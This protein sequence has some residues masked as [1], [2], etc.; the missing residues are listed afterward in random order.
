MKPMAL[1]LFLLSFPHS[2]LAAGDT[3][4][5]PC[6]EVD[7]NTSPDSPFRKI[8]VEDQDGTGLCYAYSA[9]AIANYWNVK[10][11]GEVSQGFHPLYLAGVYSRDEV[12]KDVSG[13]SVF[14]TLN[15]LKRSGNCPNDRVEKLIGTWSRTGLTYAETLSLIEDS[16]ESTIPKAQSKVSMW[17]KRFL[18]QK[19]LGGDEAS[20][21]RLTQNSAHFLRSLPTLSSNQL[22]QSM[23]AKCVPLA[24]TESIP[25]PENLTE[26]EDADFN[27]ALG[28]AM[29]DGKPAAL[30]LCSQMFN[31]GNYVGLKPGTERD[32]KNSDECGQHAVVMSGMKTI[33]GECRF[34]IRNSWG[35]DW[36]AKDRDCACIRRDGKYEEIC[37]DHS[38]AKEVVGCWFPRKSV[39]NNLYQVTTIGD[40]P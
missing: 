36:R 10:N 34:L 11:K 15:R 22:L 31:D 26:G 16:N 14:G 19:D 23:F 2:T 1:F 20:A 9:S 25:A 29:K 35:A 7:L 40:S 24:S 17:I 37:S 21:C 12:R 39:L 33:G 30:S 5:E 28:R 32:I 27:R 8:P 3:V 4:K 6:A 13:G 38:E 18:E